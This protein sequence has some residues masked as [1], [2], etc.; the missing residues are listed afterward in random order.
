M[1]ATGVIA[2]SAIT[3]LTGSSSSE[4]D[5][6]WYA[7]VVVGVVILID[8][9]RAI[10]SWRAANRYSSAALQSNALHFASDLVGSLAVLVGLILARAGHPKADPIAALVVAVIVL[11]AAPA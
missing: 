2:Y 1:V 3:R 7:F 11:V 10:V 4:V 8:L 5:P 6:T 9:A